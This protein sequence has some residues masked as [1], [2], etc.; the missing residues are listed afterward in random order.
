MHTVYL[1]ASYIDK[2]EVT[3]AQ[4]AQCVAAG[5]CTPPASDSSATRTSYYQNPAFADYPV[6]YVSWQ[7]ARNYAAWAGKR[8]PSEAEW[9]KA[10]RGANDI[11]TLSWGYEPSDCSRANYERRIRLIRG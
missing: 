8:L 6:I 3:N 4:Y 7:D 11:R 2:Y 9:E 5:A 1:N 10:A